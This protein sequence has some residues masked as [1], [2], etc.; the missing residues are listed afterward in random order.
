MSTMCETKA[1][2]KRR[3]RGNI[4]LSEQDLDMIAAYKYKPGAYT[5]VD[6][7]LTPFWNWAVTL[8]PMWMAPNLV[9]FI[10]LAGTC[11]ASLLV[12]SYSPG[13]DGD[14]VPA[15]CSLLFAVALFLYQTLD[16]IDGKQ[17]RRT[18]SSSPLGQLF[19]H[20]C[21]A[22]VKVRKQG[23]GGEKDNSV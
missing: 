3:G 18:N 19:D 5:H 13:L 4:V 7:L 6:D 23:R 21:D 12:T 14:N 2:G 16:A 20:G 9:T 17:A 10:G 8:L 11:F 15:W 22:A 1:N